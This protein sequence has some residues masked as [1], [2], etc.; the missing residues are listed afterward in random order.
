M[1]N[2]LPANDHGKQR[3]RG[4]GSLFHD[5]Y[6]DKATG[7]KVKCATW[8]MKLWVS[9]K[10]LKKPSGTTSRSVAAKQLE[11]WKAEVLQGTYVPDADKTTFDDLA[12]LLTNEY[13]A[14]GRRSTDRV[15]DAIGHLRAFF[16]AYCR[17]RAIT[18]D[19]VLAYVRHRQE[20]GAAN[21]TVNRELSALKRML[22][23]GEKVG[24]VAR[25]PHID[26]L[27]ES[28]VRTG[29]FEPEQFRALVDHLPED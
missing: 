10:A 28:N 5:T 26:M 18:T 3:E 17:A 1:M 8:T 27:Q 19:R 2:Q 22:R 21:A 15:E 29:F 16:T 13:K 20:Q 9:G 24:K 14:N 4:S 7:E 6:R 25:R 12:T 11:K 23:L